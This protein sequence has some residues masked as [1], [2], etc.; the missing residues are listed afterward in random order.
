M[1]QPEQL[2]TRDGDETGGTSWNARWGNTGKGPGVG[3]RRVEREEVKKW[4]AEAVQRE[5]DKS[6]A[7][8]RTRRQKSG[9]L[10]K[11]SNSTPRA[12]QT[13]ADSSVRLYGLGIAANRKR[14]RRRPRGGGS[15]RQPRIGEV[16]STAAGSVAG[17]GVGAG[18]WTNNSHN[19]GR[20]RGQGRKRE[21]GRGRASRRGVRQSG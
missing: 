4:Q 18:N 21:R 14:Q 20:G 3:G 16:S 5:R 8:Q 7:S 1:Q 2:P 12:I 11:P 19:R 13:A 15:R 6:G 9:A 10:S 17:L